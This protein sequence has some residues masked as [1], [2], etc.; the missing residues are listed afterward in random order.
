MN[1]V[2]NITL[3]VREEEGGWALFSKKSGGGG[4]MTEECDIDIVFHL[5]QN[6]VGVEVFM[7]E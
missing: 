2:R 6:R 7:A 1:V 5:I 4:H 3:K